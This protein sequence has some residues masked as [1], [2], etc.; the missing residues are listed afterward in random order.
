MTRFW[1]VWFGA[2][3]LGVVACADESADREENE[4]ARE[5]NGADQSEQT[6]PS[7]NGADDMSQHREAF[8]LPLPPKV[9]D[10]HR[11]DDSVDVVTTMSLDELEAFYKSRLQDFEI[12]RPPQR[13]RVLGL[14][15]YQAEI[16]GRRFAGTVQLH[17]RKTPPK[18]TDEKADDSG[19][20]DSK[21]SSSTNSTDD[22]RA[23]NESK[24]TWKLR[25]GDP[26]TERTADGELLAPGARWGEPYTPP[27]G[28]PLHKKRFES[29]WGKPYGTWVA[30]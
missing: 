28:S 18:P 14:R 1:G 12:L 29:N 24:P 9:K 4:G 15:D 6:K 22:R 19:A 10:V 11:L 27:P 25:H 8:G 30:Q 26:V 21:A 17:Y 16:Y 2:L 20:D 3:V 23:S 7:I 13:I 5:T